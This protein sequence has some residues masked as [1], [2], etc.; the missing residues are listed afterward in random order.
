MPKAYRYG[1]NLKYVC[2]VIPSLRDPS[3]PV[4]EALEEYDAVVL[5]PEHVEAGRYDNLPS[6]LKAKA[7][8]LVNHYCRPGCPNSMSHYEKCADSERSEDRHD[9]SLRGSH[10]GGSDKYLLQ[11]ED[12]ARLRDLGFEHYKLGRTNPFTDSIVQQF[13]QKPVMQDF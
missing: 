5:N 6:E 11:S 9:N 2:S 1:N 10:C 7:I 4:E 3:F 12:I 8:L 13:Q